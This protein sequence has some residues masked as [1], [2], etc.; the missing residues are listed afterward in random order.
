MQGLDDLSEIWPGNQSQTSS[1]PYFMLSLW[2]TGISLEFLDKYEHIQ[3]NEMH[4]NLEK[5]RAHKTN[6]HSHT[7]YISNNKNDSLGQ[8]VALKDSRPLQ[9]WESL[10][11][12]L[13]S[14]NIFRSINTQSD[15]PSSLIVTFLLIHKTDFKDLTQCLQTIQHYAPNGCEQSD[16]SAGVNDPDKSTVSLSL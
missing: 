1:F 4:K 13:P 8:T 14:A 9:Q 15:S 16:W 2:I 7:S 3:Q 6:L 11:S 10:F 5:T 12:C